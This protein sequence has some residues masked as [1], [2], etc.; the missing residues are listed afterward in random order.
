[1]SKRKTGL[2]TIFTCPEC[3]RVLATVDKRRKVEDQL[4]PSLGVDLIEPI[5]Q[6]RQLKCPCGHTVVLLQGEV[7]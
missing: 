2:G 1:M 4:R 6:A 7:V 5:H 3:H